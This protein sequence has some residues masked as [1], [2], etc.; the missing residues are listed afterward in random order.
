[1]KLLSSYNRILAI[2]ACSG[3]VV[4]GILFYQTLSR[5]LNRQI[6]DY[7]YEE[8]LEVRDFAHIRNI[9]PA[10]EGFTDVVVEYKRVARLRNAKYRFHDTV[11]YNPRKKRTESGRYLQT[12]VKLAD[13]PYQVTIIASKVESEEQVKSIVLIILIPLGILF[14][15]LWLVNRFLMKKMWA[16]FMRL[17]ENIRQFSLGQ[18]Q[19]YTPVETRI[20]EFRVLNDALAEVEKK[21]R[22]DY[23]EVKLFTEN[24]SHEMMTPLAVINSKLD[25]MLQSENLGIEGSILITD[26][27]KATSRLTRLNQSLLLLVKIG[28]QPLTDLEMIDL[29]QLLTEKLNYFQELIQRRKLNVSL[30]TVPASIY[31]S[32]SLVEILLNNLISNAIRHNTEGGALRISLSGKQLQVYNTSHSG[33]L[34]SSKIFDR[35][36]KDS[37][38]EGT[39]LGLAILKEICEKLGYKISY[40]WRDH[41]HCFELEFSEESTPTHTGQS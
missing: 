36:Y 11:F 15:L 26:L 31:G 18:E 24:A 35:F 30:Q 2:V 34:D 1:M 9:V 19:V 17:V 10:P 41:L 20:E 29:E 39:G 40:F 23:R 32:Y 27:Y 21:I 22:S 33:P 13:I 16:P 4:I 8:L 12:D 25:T 3:M 6:D 28:S 14:F 38:S 37:T 5:Y 7:L